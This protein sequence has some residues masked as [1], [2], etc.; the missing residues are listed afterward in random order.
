M[1]FELLESPCE[2]FSPVL[3]EFIESTCATPEKPIEINIRKV[4]LLIVFRNSS[5]V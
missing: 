2:V 4:I 5:R 3:I 1:L